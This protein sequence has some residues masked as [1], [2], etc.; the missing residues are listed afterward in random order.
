MKN[1]TETVEEVETGPTPE[2]GMN[3]TITAQPPVVEKKT[4]LQTVYEVR[5]VQS[6]L[7]NVVKK[8]E[9][10]QTVAV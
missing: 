3:V 9:V 4:G 1:V 5:Y 7:E 2:P 8:A 10:N 6:I